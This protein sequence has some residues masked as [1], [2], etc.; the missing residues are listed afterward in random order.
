MRGWFLMPTRSR[1]TSCPTRKRVLTSRAAP[2]LERRCVRDRETRNS[3]SSRFRERFFSC[4]SRTDELH[5][6]ALGHELGDRIGTGSVGRILLRDDEHLARTFDVEEARDR[7]DRARTA[8]FLHD[9]LTGR[10]VALLG[11][12]IRKLAHPTERVR[13]GSDDHMRKTF[14]IQL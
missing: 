14:Q 12:A 4:A 2:A 5:A 1:M 3:E 8:E 6:V 10:A 13:L 9:L 7:L 11:V